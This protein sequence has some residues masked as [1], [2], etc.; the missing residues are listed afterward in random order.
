MN[1]K[2]K[3]TE[4]AQ[5]KTGKSPIAWGMIGSVIL[6]ITTPFF[7]LNGKGPTTMVTSAT[8]SWKP[9]CFPWTPPPLSSTQFWPGITP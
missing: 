8:F 6:A 4:E 3:N 9:R 5:E 7:Y 2:V 1:A